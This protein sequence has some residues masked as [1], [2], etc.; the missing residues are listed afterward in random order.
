MKRVRLSMTG[1]Y[2]DMR[3]RSRLR[4]RRCRESLRIVLHVYRKRR[5]QQNPSMLLREMS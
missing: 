1:L 2:R 5:K 4:R 3:I